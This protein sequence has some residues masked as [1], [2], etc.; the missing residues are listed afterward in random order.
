[1]RHGRRG[2]RRPEKTYKPN[3]VIFLEY[4]LH[5]PGPDPLANKDTEEREKYYG[6]AI[7]GTPTM[8][9][10]GKAGPPPEGAARTTLRENMTS[11]AA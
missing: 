5:I 11:I 1:M 6:K 3:D 10:D 9:V 7:E 8:F 2:V 4:H